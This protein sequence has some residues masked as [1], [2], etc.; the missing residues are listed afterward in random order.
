VPGAG[1][2][3]RL[4][5]QDNRRA[6][7]EGRKGRIAL[8]RH[9]HRRDAHILTDHHRL[10]GSS[11]QVWL[12]RVAILQPHADIPPEEVPLHRRGSVL[13]R[14]L[15]ELEEAVEAAFLAVED[16]VRCEVVQKLALALVGVEVDRLEHV[17]IPAAPLQRLVPEDGPEDV[18]AVL[19]GGQRV[20][21]LSRRQELVPRGGRVLRV[22]PGFLKQRLVVDHQR[23][24]R[25]NRDIVVVAVK[26]LDGRR[27]QAVVQLL[28]AG[29][30]FQ[31]HRRALLGERAKL[32][33]KRG[34][35]QVWL[36][37][38]GDQRLER[39]A[40]RLQLQRDG[41]ARIGFLIRFD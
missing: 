37:A 5:L 21:R 27:F 16:D 20:D 38:G 22:E 2:A 28:R 9:R 12:P 13:L 29:Q 14:G 6:S 33:P 31:R 11:L 15:Q 35:D 39:A 1:L 23:D 36:V 17:P 41:D 19:A 34:D 30:V 18:V 25:A 4:G 10:L 24:V 26:L 3:L 8:F 40:F 32:R 7:A